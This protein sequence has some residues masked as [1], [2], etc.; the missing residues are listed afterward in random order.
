MEK[1]AGPPQ[2]MSGLRQDIPYSWLDWS[3]PML[4]LCAIAVCAA[5]A[6]FAV[7][8]LALGPLAGMPRAGLTV[9]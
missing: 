4:A 2:I 5:I 1:L 8:I 9:Q 6:G 3:C 7:V